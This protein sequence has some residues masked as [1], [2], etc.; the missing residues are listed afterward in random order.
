MHR[1]S[2]LVVLAS[3]FVRPG[4]AQTSERLKFGPLAMR[5]PHGYR[6]VRRA[7]PVVLAGPG[8]E[9]VTISVYT[10]PAGAERADAAPQEVRRVVERHAQLMQSAAEN[11][12][13]VIVPVAR[14]ELPDGSTLLSAASQW[15]GFSTSYLLQFHVVSRLGHIAYVTVEGRGRF[16][17]T[18]HDR[19]LPLFQSVQWLAGGPSA[20]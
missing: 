1:R 8:N 9:E 12:G 3:C 16:A 5:W 19:L 17:A 7:D 18:R 4:Q 13:E 20:A 10:P 6:V 15:R 2:V 14:K 11:F